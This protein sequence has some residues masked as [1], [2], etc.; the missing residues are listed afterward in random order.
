MN[1]TASVLVTFAIAISAALG[2]AVT[3]FVTPTSPPVPAQPIVIDRQPVIPPGSVMTSTGRI[4]RFETEDSN[5]ED[6]LFFD[7][8][9]LGG[10]QG[11]PADSPTGFDGEYF[12]P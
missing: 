7:Y 11:D 4:A 5:F 9:E 8:T 2:S 1:R 10:Q 3:M 12:C 6:C